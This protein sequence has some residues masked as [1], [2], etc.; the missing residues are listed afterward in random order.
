[1]PEILIIEDSPPIREI[2]ALLLAGWGYQVR[3]RKWRLLQ[4]HVSPTPKPSA[5]LHAGLRF[6]ASPMLPGMQKASAG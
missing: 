4:N 3:L 6:P 5:A 2:Y 1:M